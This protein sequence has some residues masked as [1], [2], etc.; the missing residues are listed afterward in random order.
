MAICSLGVQSPLHALDPEKRS[1]GCSQPHLGPQPCTT[2]EILTKML[3]DGALQTGVCGVQV[4][5]ERH[6]EE[7]RAV[8]V[9][10]TANCL[11]DVLVRVQTACWT[12]LLVAATCMG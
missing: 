5:A 6:S 8:C 12:D 10:I 4:A 3:Q 7:L 1:Q 9:D 2:P 11:P